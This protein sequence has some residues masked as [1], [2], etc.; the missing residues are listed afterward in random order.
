MF[1]LDDRTGN[2]VTTVAVFAAAASILYLARGAFF[3]LL[4]SLLFAYLL[5]PAVTLVQRH[6]RLGRGS[7]TWAI[8]QV[9]LVG[10]VGVGIFGYVLRPHL[11]AQIKSLSA[12][13]PQILNDLSSGSAAATLGER[14]G[15]SATQQ[16]GIRDWLASHRDLIARGVESGAASAGYV[17]ARAIW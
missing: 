16:L 10:A 4:L 17:I 11:V 12:A 7:R 3:I 1:A 6:S 9:Y 8:A 2:V 15:L 14:H 5:E 13:L